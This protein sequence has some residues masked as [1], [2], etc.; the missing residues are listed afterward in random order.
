M[1]A[2]GCGHFPP[3]NMS[4]YMTG[5]YSVFFGVS[6]TYHQEVY[7]SIAERQEII[8]ISGSNPRQNWNSRIHK[9]GLGVY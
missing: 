5:V 8:S 1:N 4:V 9:I 7:K 3:K 2:M 6:E